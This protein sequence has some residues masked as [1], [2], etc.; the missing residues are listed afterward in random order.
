MLVLFTGVQDDGVAAGAIADSS[1]SVKSI[2]TGTGVAGAVTG[3]LAATTFDR[4][5]AAALAAVAGGV[6]DVG[7]AAANGRPP[8]CKIWIFLFIAGTDEL[9]AGRG[10]PT[11]LAV[12][13]RLAGSPRA[14]VAGSAAAARPSVAPPIPT[15]ASTC[16]NSHFPPAQSESPAIE[17]E[18]RRATDGVG[19]EE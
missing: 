6:R 11:N 19:Q 8:A 10:V 3:V 9:A 2:T 17:T 5:A 18:Q 12:F 1:T 15:A 13:D 14:S 4:F 16:P 7:A